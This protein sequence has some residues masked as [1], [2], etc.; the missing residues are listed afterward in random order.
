MIGFEFKKGLAFGI[1][2]ALGLPRHNVSAASC[3]RDDVVKVVLVDVELLR[4]WL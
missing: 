4:K 3:C 1:G 2:L